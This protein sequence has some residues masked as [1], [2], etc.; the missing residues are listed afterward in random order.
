LLGLPRDAVIVLWLG[1]LSSEKDPLAFVEAIARIAAPGVTALIAGAGELSPDVARAVEERSLGS[2]VRLLGWVDDPGDVLGAADLFVSTSRWEGIALAAL[3]AAASGLALVLTD[4]P[5]NRDLA[6]AGVPAV[7]VPPANPW[8]LASAIDELA[9]EADRRRMLGRKS[10]KVVRS[11]FTPEALA[12]DVLAVYADVTARRRSV[13][14]R[15]VGPWSTAR[16][17]AIGSIV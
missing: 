1:R 11:T 2:R 13:F 17:G 4:V 9:V 3:E 8:R 10:A 12:R 5:G 14:H 7:L 6:A 15:P 16:R